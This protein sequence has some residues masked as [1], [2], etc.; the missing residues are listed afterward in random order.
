MENFKKSPQLL[1]AE[2]R[3]TRKTTDSNK[4]ER[5]GILNSPSPASGSCPNTYLH[6]QLPLS[7]ITPSNSN[8]NIDS[9]F[10]ARLTQSNPV[11]I[12]N[13]FESPSHVQNQHFFST[14][15][16]SQRSST[17]EKAF[18]ITDISVPI[19]QVGTKRKRA[20]TISK[21]GDQMETI[22]SDCATQNTSHHTQ[23]N[24]VVNINHPPPRQHHYQTRG[25]NLYNKFTAAL[26]P[27]ETSTST[28]QIPTKQKSQYSHIFHNHC[29]DQ[30]SSE[31]DSDEHSDS[32]ESS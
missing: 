4:R 26:N 24:D 31:S 3:K 8:N 30:S 28:P 25:V 12:P 7:D 11:I 14:P 1:A 23:Q 27:N 18:Y 9:Q 10:S 22:N 17:Q 19:A 15:S 16:N 21:S 32:A 13:R 5:I 29:I 20:D 2:A 6:E